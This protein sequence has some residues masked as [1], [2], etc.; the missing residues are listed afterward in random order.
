M[1]TIRGG[2]TW[3]HAQQ[4]YGGPTQQHAISSVSNE[5]AYNLPGTQPHVQQIRGGKGGRK[6]KNNKKTL[7]KNK[8]KKTKT[9]RSKSYRKR[10]LRG[11][12]GVAGPIGGAIPT[13][14]DDLLA[15][16]KGLSQQYSNLVNPI[17]IGAPPSSSPIHVDETK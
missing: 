13:N 3:Q 9:R 17:D 16:Q 14:L 2:N 6:T 8:N 15:M 1:P 4:V 10:V 7:K 12:Q 5:I 11:G